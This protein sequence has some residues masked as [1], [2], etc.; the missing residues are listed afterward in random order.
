M[1]NN[2]KNSK[3]NKMMTQKMTINNKNK[4]IIIL[5]TIISNNQPTIKKNKHKNKK[6]NKI[7]TYKNE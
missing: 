1:T 2:N 7:K 3:L 5:R 4:K 6:N